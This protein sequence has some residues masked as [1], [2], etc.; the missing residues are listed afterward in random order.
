MRIPRRAASGLA[1][2]ILVLSVG[3][4]SSSGSSSDTSSSSTG[5][6]GASSSSASS[7]INILVMAD[8]TGPT[9]AYGSQEL[10]GLMA[11]VNYYN[12][13]GGID[14][15]KVVVTHISDN[16]DPATSASLLVNELSTNPGKF[17]MVYGGAEGTVIQALIPVIARYPVIAA[18]AGDD[19]LCSNVKTCPHQFSQVGPNSLPQQTD[20]TWMQSKGYKKV[21]I[22]EEQIAF[23]ESETPAFKADLTT[24]GISNSEATFTDSAV[25]LTAEMSQLKAAGAQ[26]V[27]VLAVGPA[28]GYA[29]KARAALNWNV[30]ILFDDAASSFDITT[31][32]SKSLYANSFQTLRPVC[33]AT[34]AS[35]AYKDLV[36]NLPAGTKITLPANLVADGWD[37]IVMLDS[38]V[39]QAHSTNY[40]ALTSALD[41]LDAAGQSNP[42]YL[43]TP[44]LQFSATNHENIADVPGN[45][46]IVPVQPIVNGQVATGSK[47]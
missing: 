13:K 36:A 27:F 1:A 2:S 4:C 18:A 21:G 29:L 45:F 23:T 41:N 14:G 10:A 17:T 25:D 19:S 5:G 40:E 47:S 20:A 33:V 16:G 34:L 26:A 6:T 31:L 43:L 32:V 24:A 7:T 15:H 39:T 12:N 30:P 35:P 11:A 28:A 37:P 3:A 44:K 38:A 9:K 46:A 22:L 42:E 8:T